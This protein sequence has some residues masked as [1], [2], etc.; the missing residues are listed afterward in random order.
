[1]SSTESTVV[2]KGYKLYDTEVSLSEKAK[3]LKTVLSH[4]SV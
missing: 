1:M 4:D 3:K 2:W